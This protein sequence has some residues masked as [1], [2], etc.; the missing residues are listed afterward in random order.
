MPLNELLAEPAKLRSEE[1]Q[2]VHSLTSLC[3]AEYGTFLSLK[4]AEGRLRGSVE[5]V[6]DGLDN[7]LGD[8]PSIGTTTQLT[9][10]GALPSLESRIKSF[11]T[12]TSPLKS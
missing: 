2:L 8:Q 11:T 3:H 12:L 1:S 10:Q 9:D 7:I 6:I 5:S 4:D